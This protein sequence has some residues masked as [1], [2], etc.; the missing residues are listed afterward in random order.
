MVTESQVASDLVCKTLSTMIADA[1]ALRVQRLET[2]EPFMREL[3]SVT[4][5]EE[6]EAAVRS[7]TV[8]LGTCGI[9]KNVWSWRKPLPQDVLE[10][11]LCDILAMP[12]LG[13]VRSDFPPQEPGPPPPEITNEIDKADVSAAPRRYYQELVEEQAICEPSRLAWLADDCSRQGSSKDV[14]WPMYSSIPVLLL[15]I[16]LLFMHSAQIW[17]PQAVMASIKTVGAVPHHHH[18]HHHPALAQFSSKGT[19]AARTKDVR[20]FFLSPYLP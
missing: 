20:Q 4:L 3:R 18:H 8:R 13:M 6:L 12:D 2:Q 14:G 7:R 5:A 9:L 19:T 1:V 17:R 10:V 15:I 11:R 16:W